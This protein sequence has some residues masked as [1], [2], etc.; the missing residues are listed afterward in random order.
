MS[1]D[2]TTSATTVVNGDELNYTLQVT[3]TGALTLDPV[4]VDDLLPSAVSY[5]TGTVAGGAGTCTLTQASKPQ[6]VTCTFDDALAPGADA[7][8]I[9]LLVKVDNIAEGVEVVNEA[10]VRGVYDAPDP[11]AENDVLGE[12]GLTCVPTEGE[13][14][15]MSPRAAVTGGTATTTTE[16]AP[17]TTTQ[18]GSGSATTTIVAELPP[19]GSNGT[20]T[21]VWIGGLL[22]AIGGAIT[23]S[24]RR[25]TA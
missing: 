6:L 2:K 21:M 10:R 8:T 13:V 25:R 11:T 5:V 20:N 12:A 24:V 19:T 18:V 7:P 22:L 16:P 15:D 3:N 23:L 17:T 9:T 14:C 1:I 4:V